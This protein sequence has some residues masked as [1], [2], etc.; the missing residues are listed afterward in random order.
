MRSTASSCSSPNSRFRRATK[1][2]SRATAAQALDDHQMRD[3][4][5]TFGKAFVSTLKT[6]FKEQAE[7]W[8]GSI[9][10]QQRLM[11]MVF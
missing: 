4:F 3:V 1:R 10:T 5:I 11:K 8:S 7:R 6:L 9:E 2:R